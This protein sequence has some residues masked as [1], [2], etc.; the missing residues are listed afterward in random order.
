MSG[1][2]VWSPS[3]KQLLA[4]EKIIKEEGAW[5]LDLPLGST[6]LGWL[7]EAQ[8]LARRVLGSPARYYSYNLTTG[9]IIYLPELDTHE[10]YPRGDG[11]T[12][13]W[14]IVREVFIGQLKAS[15]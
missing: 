8:I 9:R 3:G 11:K 7:D 15:D 12:I 2:I 4:G 6:T 5:F 1:G 13:A 10:V 14:A